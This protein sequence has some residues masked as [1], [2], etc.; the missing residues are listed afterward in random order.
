MTMPPPMISPRVHLPGSGDRSGDPSPGNGNATGSS[1]G[2]GTRTWNNFNGR[3]PDLIYAGE[4]IKLPDGTTHVVQAGETLSSIA[5]KYGVSVDQLI[6][7]NGFDRALLGKDPQG[8]YFDPGNGPQPSPGGSVAPP[9]DASL[10]SP[11]AD[12]KYTKDQATDLAKTVQD[13][14]AKGK[15][16]DAVAD[17]VLGLLDKVVKGTITADETA[18]LTKLLEQVKQAQGG[19]STTAGSSAGVPTSAEATALLENFDALAKQGNL[20]HGEAGT[21]KMLLK[22]VEADEPLSSAEKTTLNNLLSKVRQGA[23]PGV[24]TT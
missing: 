18:K 24:A 1:N 13:L 5:A 19:S 3:D 10:F 17:E 16:D 22:K 9:P 8:R 7:K 20:T 14:K 23:T 6:E 21:L 11:G 15:L 12:G 4:T 2:S